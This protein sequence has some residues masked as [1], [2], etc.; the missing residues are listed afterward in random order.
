MEDYIDYTV[1]KD[2][3][4]ETFQ[5]L[6]SMI[7]DEQFRVLDKYIAFVQMDKGKKEFNIVCNKGYQLFEETVL[8]TGIFGDDL[9]NLGYVF[10]V[11]GYAADDKVNDFF[12]IVSDNVGVILYKDGKLYTNCKQL[13]DKYEYD[14]NI[15]LNDVFTYHN[16]QYAIMELD[17]DYNLYRYNKI[18]K[19]A[20][21]R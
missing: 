21:Q 11:K 3:D 16:E 6:L 13:R 10:V 1:E 2:E 8:E 4:L 19:G 9:D 18:K 7:F 5:A 12:A 17:K 15:R 14:E 20:I